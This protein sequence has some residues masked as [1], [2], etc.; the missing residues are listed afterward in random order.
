VDIAA[1]DVADAGALA[2]LLAAVPA[3]HPLTAVFHA[4]GTVDGGIVASLSAERLA[5]VL[6]PKVDAAWNLHTQTRDLPLAAFVIYSSLSGML[7]NPGQ[8]NYAAGNSFLDSLAHYRRAAGLP[9]SAL[10]WGVWADEDGMAERLSRADM[11][12]MT[13]AGVIP[14]PSEQALAMLDVTLTLDQPVTAPAEFDP[15]ALRTLA[16][17][18]TLPPVLAGLAGPRVAAAP[19]DAGLAERLA[20]QPEPERRKSVTNLVRTRAA[21]VLGYD[22]PG[23]IDPQKSFSALGFDSLLAVELRNQLSVVMNTQ[24]PASLVF[25]HPTPVKLAEHLLTML[26]SAGAA[27]DP[28][29][30]ELDRLEAAVRVSTLADSARAKAAARVRAILWSLDS[31]RAETDEPDTDVSDLMTDS[32]DQLFEILDQ[33]LGAS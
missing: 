28:V 20:A 11:A 2:D 17:A 24:L 27:P 21:A 23:A 9:G 13:G 1:C 31:H 19:A 32:D 26:A 3:T 16:T 22:S 33:E 6:R 12:R 25:D 4:A 5:C 18:G 14:L 15:A 8:A 30:A 10:A 29:L 7:G